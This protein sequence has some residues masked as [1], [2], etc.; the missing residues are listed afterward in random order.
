MR[1]Q[2]T[3]LVQLKPLESAVPRPPEDSS[4]QDGSVLSLRHV[5]KDI[6]FKGRCV[7][8]IFVSAVLLVTGD[9]G[10]NRCQLEGRE[11]GGNRELLP[12]CP[13]C[14]TSRQRGCLLCASRR[15]QRRGPR[16]PTAITRP[17]DEETWQRLAPDYTYEEYIA[18]DDDITVWGTLEDADI[19]RE[20]QESSKEEGE[21]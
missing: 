4:K 18:A 2:K 1:C 16:L 7:V 17:C 8:I 12:T 21:E 13:L 14:P 20:Q 6:L 11:T 10:R 9:H 15:C 5:C 19:I 3:L